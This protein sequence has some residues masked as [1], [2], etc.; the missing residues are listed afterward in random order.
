MFVLFV[1][2]LYILRILKSEIVLGLN[3]ASII[4]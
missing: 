1:L 3:P 2:I 4:Y